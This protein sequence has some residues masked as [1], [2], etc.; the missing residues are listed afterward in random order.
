MCFGQHRARF[1][2]FPKA[3]PVFASLRDFA[4]ILMQIGVSYGDTPEPPIE[5][6]LIQCGSERA[7]RL[8]R[9]IIPCSLSL[10]LSRLPS[11]V[12][13]QWIEPL[14]SVYFFLPP[15]PPLF[16]FFLLFFFFFF[17]VATSVVRPLAYVISLRGGK[18]TEVGLGFFFFKIPDGGSV[19][20]RGL[21]KEKWVYF[22]TRSFEDD[23]RKSCSFSP[24]FVDGR[25]DIDVSQFS[26]SWIF[27]FSSFLLFI[28]WNMEM[29]MILNASRRK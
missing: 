23:F 24:T 14:L 19:R 5:I 2:A 6:T 1:G 3:S 28:I 15:L 12:Q 25:M 18:W 4:P 17:Y 16:F 10:S 13:R 7:T 27:L 8:P 9:S 11:K 26:F 21:M 22:S 20:R 29:S